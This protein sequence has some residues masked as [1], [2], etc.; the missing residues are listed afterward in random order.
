MRFHQTYTDLGL[1][2]TVHSL[3]M[4]T[5]RKHSG[6]VKLLFKYW[7]LY[8]ENLRDDNICH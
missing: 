8:L 5:L 7:N 1:F 4:Y 3:N 2:G 6:Q